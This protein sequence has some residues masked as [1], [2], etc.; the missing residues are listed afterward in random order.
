M[1]RKD[2]ERIAAAVREARECSRGNFEQEIGVSRVAHRLAYALLNDNE[3]FDTDRFLAACGFP[4]L[5]K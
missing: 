4:S 1:T 3:R 5:V 2:Y